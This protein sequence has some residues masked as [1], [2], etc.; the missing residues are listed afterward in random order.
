MKETAI[1]RIGKMGYASAP[2]L[3]LLSVI[4]SSS[5]STVGDGEI[6]ARRFFDRS[7]GLTYAS[8]LDIA[9]FPSDRDYCIR[10]ILAAFWF[11]KR[12]AHNASGEKYVIDDPEA[13]A[14]FFKDLMALKQEHFAIAMLDSKNQCI[15]RRTIHIGTLDM[16]VVSA[17]DVFRE[18]IREG[19]A[20][21]IL[22]HNHPSGDPTPS[23]E[24][25]AI[26]RKLVSLGEELDILVLDHIIIGAD[27]HTSLKKIGALR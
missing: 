16:S 9:D 1:D 26:T 17:R 23:P 6:F 8:E 11:G 14:K 13:A 4:F 18:A 21:I 10:R 15:A 24:D 3:D 25:I 5:E 7:H 22:A 2:M 12:A 27:R 20:S 19:S